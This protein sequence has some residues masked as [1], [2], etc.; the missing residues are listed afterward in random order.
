M[1]KFYGM[2]NVGETILVRVAL[3]IIPLLPRWLVLR[4]ARGLEAG[5]LRF[6]RRYRDRSM[7][8]LAL[9]FG[10]ELTEEE[11]RGIARDA[12]YSFIMVVLDLFWFSRWTIRRIE[13]WVNFD[14]SFDPYFQNRPVIAVSGHFGNWEILGLGTAVRGCPPASVVAPM[15]NPALDRMLN[16]IRV[17]TGQQVIPQKGAVRGMIRVLRSGERVAI[18]IDQNVIPR[19][20]GVFLDFFQ[21]PV[22]VT[23]VLEALVE[24]TGATVVPVYSRIMPDGRYLA[25]GGRPMT[26]ASLAEWNGDWP[27]TRH[28]LADLEREILRFPGY[29]NWMYKRWK[30]IPAGEDPGRYPY[31]ARFLE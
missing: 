1:S 17:L 28:C 19:Q 3:G 13:K 29:W 12:L 27:V 18:L 5:A 14:V 11:R 25:Y 16:R 30:Y 23:P 20:G 10:D 4:L 22:P 7:A 8:N 31:Y 15:Q 21:R 6:S 2:R 26:P 24:K 9:V